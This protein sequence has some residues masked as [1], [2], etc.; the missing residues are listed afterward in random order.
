MARTRMVRVHNAYRIDNP[1]ELIVIIARIVGWLVRRVWAFRTELGFVVLVLVLR[2]Q[3]ARVLGMPWATVVTVVLIVGLMVWGPVR[4]FVVGRWWCAFYRRRLLACL[5]E[6]RRAS[7]NVSGRLPR[8]LRSRRTPVGARLRLFCL[9]GHSA[10]GMATHVDELRAACN[11]RDVR[12]TR[13]RR[14][15]AL[16]DVDIVR[17]D[18]L[19]DDSDPI[20]SPLSGLADGVDLPEGMPPTPATTE[21][22]PVAATSNGAAA[23]GAGGEDVSDYV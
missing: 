5:R 22:T 10:E 17:E 7:D 23:Y 19:T 6:T 13:H 20:G 16:V 8:I 18:P 4:R 12:V 21:K 14:Y 3:V 1:I 9:P 11:A 2:H 15:G